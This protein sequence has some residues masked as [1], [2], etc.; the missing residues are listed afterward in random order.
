MSAITRPAAADPAA[1][2]QQRHST[3]SS[4]KRP[5]ELIVACSPMRSNVNLSQ[6][7]RTAS[8]CAV[9]RMI[10]CGTGRLVQKVAR[11]GADHLLVEHRRSLRPVLLRL[12]AEGYQI[13]GL[14]Q[15]TH[16]VSL[17]SYP[18]VRRTVLV[19]GNE[20]LGL[21][22]EVL[23][24]VHA[25]VEIPVWGLPHSHNAATAATMALYEYCRQLPNG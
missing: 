10:I 14:E 19:I 5:R 20:R 21:S 23:D 2:V 6:I 15:A 11:D 22:P 18:F 1:F 25:C 13:V 24:V 9:D 12:A 8:T 7:A 16:S 17:H 3:P 4:L